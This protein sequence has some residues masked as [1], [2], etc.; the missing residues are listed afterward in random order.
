[1][2]TLPIKIKQFIAFIKIP[3]IFELNQYLPVLC[4]YCRVESGSS[5]H[6]FYVSTNICL[7]SAKRSTGIALY[8]QVFSPRDGEFLLVVGRPGVGHLHHLAAPLLPRQPIR[9]EESV[10]SINET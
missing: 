8:L 4:F 9:C 2:N 1:M 3:C 6:C 10:M 5:V 7:L